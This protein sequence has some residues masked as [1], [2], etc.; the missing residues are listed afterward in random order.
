MKWGG[1]ADDINTMM[2]SI[3]APM[4]LAGNGR[5]VDGDNG[6]TLSFDT[7]YSSPHAP[8]V[9]LGEMLSH[10]SRERNR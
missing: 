7:K 1:H 4:A 6:R 5:T 8:L 10:R 2:N 9:K 3:S